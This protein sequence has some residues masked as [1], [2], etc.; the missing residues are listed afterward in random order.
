VT[1]RLYVSRLRS[2][3]IIP[4]ALAIVLLAAAGTAPRP[5][6]AAVASH[7]RLALSTP[8]QLAS[9][10][11]DDRYVVL[12]AWESAEARR[13]KA[14][15]PHLTVLV[16]QDFG[17]MTVGLG[18]DDLSSSGVGYAQARTRHP[19][20]FLT[21]RDGARIQERGYPYLFMADVGN[22]GYQRDWAANVVR[23][24][25]RG[26]WD[27]V[28]M[29]DVNTS[30]RPEAG[31]AVI[32]R[33]PT[34]RDYEAA[35][36]SMLA[37][38]GPKIHATGKLAIANMG[39]WA[40]HPAVVR[41]WLSYVDG[42]MD[43]KFVKWAP[44]P[45]LGYRSGRQWLSQE[46]EVLTTE[47][48]GKQFLA[49]T[50]ASRRDSRAQLY[51]WAS[52]LLV[53]DGRASYLA[54][55]SYTGAEQQLGAYGARLGAPVD[56]MTEGPGGVFRRLF[57]RGL[58]V[59][60]PTMQTVRVSLGGAFSGSGVTRAS[61]VTLG[62]ERGLVLVGVRSRAAAHWWWGAIAGA[63]VIGLILLLV[64]W[65]R[66]RRGGGDLEP[67]VRP[68]ASRRSGVRIRRGGPRAGRQA[69]LTATPRPRG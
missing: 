49:V 45:G 41:S 12:Q 65:R 23:L 58:V 30:P 1:L 54:S 15:E 34:D 36:R 5:A 64:L 21:T 11:R 3:G 33:Y 17:S 38:V 24:L 10:R 7:F 28:F 48:A 22:A 42:G 66:A 61:A 27:G 50:D 62:P 37:Y 35:V 6:R 55:D 25:R 43:E 20:W 16:Y 4:V 18:P 31:S 52:L 32:A 51:G 2:V 53:A 59:V 69:R 13:L 8:P 56:G 14:A 60:N 26:P 19:S 57:A 44:Q 39:D 63:A 9:V 68:G 67:G 47:S 29:D 40:G 46:R